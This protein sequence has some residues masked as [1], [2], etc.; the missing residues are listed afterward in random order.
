[1]LFLEPETSVRYS[2]TSGCLSSHM[3][4][5]ALQDQ[6][7]DSRGHLTPALSSCAAKLYKTS[8]SLANSPCSPK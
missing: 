8:V 5:L 4:C 2:R 7:V 6:L 3:H 1:M